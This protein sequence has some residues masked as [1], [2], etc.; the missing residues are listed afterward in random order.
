MACCPKDNQARLFVP[1]HDPTDSQICRPNQHFWFSTTN[2]PLPWINQLSLGQALLASP[3]FS[4]MG[5]SCLAPALAYV[6][7]T[8]KP[9]SSRQAH[10]PETK[11]QPQPKGQSAPPAST[12][13]SS[14]ASHSLKSWEEYRD[15]QLL[16]RFLKG[17]FLTVAKH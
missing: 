9:A 16:M 4:T 2:Q 12:E 1:L 15:Y 7:H 13:Q 6:L 17:K 3:S 11:M 14:P 5:E 8:K 10:L